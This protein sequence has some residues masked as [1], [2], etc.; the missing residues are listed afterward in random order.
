MKKP[1]V[2]LLSLF[3]VSALF[4]QSTYRNPVIPGFHPDPSICRVGNDYYIV[5][6]SFEYFPGV[7][8]SHSTD[9]VNWK[10]IGNVLNRESQLPLKGTS[11]WTGIYAPTLRYNAGTWY[12]ITTNVG[13]GG[14]FM[15]TATSP[16]GPWSDPIWL[17][18]KGIDPSL[19]FEDGKCYM[20]SN[21]GD[22]IWLCEI[23]AKTGK[24]LTESKKLWSGDGGRY[25]EGPHIYKKD[26]FYYLLISEGGTELAHHLTIARSKNIYGPY[27]SNPANPILTNCNMLGQNS[28]IQGTGHGDFVQSPDGSWWLTFLAYRNF[29][30]LYHHLGRE[31]YIA[32]VEWKVGGWPVVN[33]GQ[34]IDTLMKAKLPN[35]A[36]QTLADVTVNGVD[37]NDPGWLYIQNKKAGSYSFE[38][39]K[40]R[41]YANGSLI[42]NENPTFI[43]R[44]QMS[45]KVMMEAEVTP[46]ESDTASVSSEF[47]L[48][49]YQINDGY[50]SM[51][52]QDNQV[53]VCCRL[54]SAEALSDGYMLPEGNEKVKLRIRSD[55]NMYYF[56]V[57]EEGQSYHQIAAHNC[58]IISTE[59]AG[60]FTGVV[61]GMYV[62]GLNKD[63]YADFD[64]F[65]Y[66]EL[67]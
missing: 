62:G 12:M 38:N 59:V 32:P 53:Y 4:A 28:Q 52:V 45:E 46:H 42:K 60:G 56:D 64:K 9:L 47:G 50:F 26:G 13:N 5:N 6:S 10:Q 34:P 2:F 33:G 21:P 17:D 24:Q 18:Q 67:K 36:K 29:G 1:I 25:P 48:C 27:E 22:A 19:Y 3:C 39:G 31:T 20:C 54:K 43:G 14:N 41:L 15:V 66:K 51:Y 57:A 16:E 55:G 58:S 63:A 7:P 61:L 65:V 23:D 37:A 8:I 49:A 40:A 44:R 11:S 35:N 30:G